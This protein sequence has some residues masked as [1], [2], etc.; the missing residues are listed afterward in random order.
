[1]YDADWL[2]TN[3]QFPSFRFESWI[4]N[5]AG[6]GNTKNE[7]RLAPFERN[8]ASVIR[9]RAR[10][11]VPQGGFKV[12]GNDVSAVRMDMLR[13]LDG[14]RTAGT[15]QELVSF[16]DAVVTMLPESEHVLRAYATM[17]E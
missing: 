14:A 7:N 13:G 2:P 9:A 12:M 16:A 1:M 17:L 8:N 4:D 11:F 15:L 5:V 10:V 3:D 6:H